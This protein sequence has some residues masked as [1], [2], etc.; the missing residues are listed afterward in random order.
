MSLDLVDIE[1]RRVSKTGYKKKKKTKKIKKI[2]FDV[3]IFKTK[4]AE[5]KK[6]KEFTV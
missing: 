4:T 3:D 1:D 5:N 6:V 2:Y